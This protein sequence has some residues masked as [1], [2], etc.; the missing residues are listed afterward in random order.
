M[1]NRRKLIS[2]K[3]RKCGIGLS[4]GYPQLLCPKCQKEQEAIDEE[5]RIAGAMV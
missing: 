3:C 5:A 1:A 2:K 4:T